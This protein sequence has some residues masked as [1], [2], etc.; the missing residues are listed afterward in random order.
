MMAATQKRNRL[1]RSEVADRRTWKEAEAP[2]VGDRRQCGKLQGLGIIGTHS[3]YFEVRKVR[4]DARRRVA[5][6]FAGDIDRDI[7]EWLDELL[8]QTTHLRTRAA[9]K[10]DKLAPFSRELRDLRGMTS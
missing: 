10:L 8:E 4:C 9:A 6:Q 2:S 1:V 3:E 7:G 5:Q